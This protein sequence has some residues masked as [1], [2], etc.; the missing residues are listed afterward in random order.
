M[1]SVCNRLDEKRPRA[2]DTHTEPGKT[3]HAFII[4]PLS[5]LGAGGPPALDEEPQRHLRPH[6]SARWR[7]GALLPEPGTRRG[8][9]PVAYSAGHREVPPA[10]R[11]GLKRTEAGGAKQD[12]RTAR[13]LNRDPSE[14]SWTQ[15]GVQEGQARNRHAKGLRIPP[16]LTSGTRTPETSRRA[17]GSRAPF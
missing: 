7:V 2:C 8:S 14:T 4:K 10:Q 3:R 12:P 9:A 6:R 1:R 17:P 5:P 16:R 13:G 15:G 11:K